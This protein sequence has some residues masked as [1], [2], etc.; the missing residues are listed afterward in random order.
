[1]TGSSA[2]R[3]RGSSSSTRSRSSGPTSRRCSFARSRR[4]SSSRSDKLKTSD[5]LLLAGSNRDLRERVAQG[6][7]REDLLARINLW[8]FDLP[9]LRERPEDIAPNLD[10]EL[11]RFGRTN[12]TLATFNREA[13]ERFLAFATAPDSAWRGNF[14]DFGAAV[15]RMA[16]LAEG[17][18]IGRAQVDDEIARLRASWNRDRTEGAEGA[19]VVA[20]VLGAEA[21][22][23]L[24][25]FDRVQL[26]DV[27]TVCRASASLSAAGRTLFARSRA[28]K[29]SANDA[30]RLRK[31]LGKFGLTWG[32]RGAERRE[33]ED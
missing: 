14:R 30:D 4:R 23:Q 33:A 27:L 9:G 26:A 18:R 31:Y 13:R 28:K 5:F 7:F 20:E 12:G 17:G 10:F 24:D 3:T 15:L 22:A 16:T 8:T 32:E 11:E 21:A 25:R 2:A 29:Q 19:D 1:V 6:R